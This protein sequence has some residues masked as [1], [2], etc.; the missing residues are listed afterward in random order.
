MDTAWVIC[1]A[2][3]KEAVMIAETWSVYCEV[4]GSQRTF[5]IRILLLLRVTRLTRRGLCKDQ[6]T[7]FPEP[8]SSAGCICK[9]SVAKLGMDLSPCT[10]VRR[11]PGTDD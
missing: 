6:R 8:L 2:L 11:S 7:G 4:V 3:V 5:C 10:S 9:I 1:L